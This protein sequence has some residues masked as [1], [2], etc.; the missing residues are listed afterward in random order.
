MKLLETV[1][2]C[3]FPT[4]VIFVDDN[5]KF[6]ENVHMQL[7]TITAT[8]RYFN[9]P[10]EAL[11]FLN[12]Y[13][14]DPFTRRCL[15]QEETDDF[16]QRAI[17]V[18]IKKI[19]QEIY[20]ANRYYQVSVLVL[21]YA[22]P[23]MTGKELLEKLKDPHFKIILLTGEANHAKAVQLF[24]EGKIHYFIR[25]D[26]PNAIPGLKEAILRF[27]HEYFL[28]LSKPIIDSIINKA[29]LFNQTP[30]CLNDLVFIQFFNEFKE[31]YH[32][33]QYYLFDEIGSFLLLNENNELSWLVVLNE[34]EMII[35]ENEMNESEVKI[36]SAL[37]KAIKNREVLRY[38][39]NAAEHPALNNIGE[40]KTLF[41]PATKLSGKNLYYY[42]HIIKPLTNPLINV[43]KILLRNL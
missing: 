6:L 14:L 25:K 29:V 1:P 4:T 27:Q 18:K 16:D 19:Y 11:S 31:K 5:K 26:E 42:S 37:L 10:Q 39:F 35:T 30:S 9:N 17:H 38:C 3:Y 13:Q 28:D 2:A 36:S 21:D 15:L 34:E 23:G 12:Q 20:N 24:N 41:Y 32:I 22:M 7:S 8:Y 33:E 40:G 43:K